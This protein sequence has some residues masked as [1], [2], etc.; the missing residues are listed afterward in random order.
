MTDTVLSVGQLASSQPTVPAKSALSPAFNSMKIYGFLACCRPAPV[1]AGRGSI[2]WQLLKEVAFSERG[3]LWSMRRVIL[4][5]VL[6]HLRS[7][8]ACCLTPALLEWTTTDPENPVSHF[9]WCQITSPPHPIATSVCAHI[10]SWHLRIDAIVFEPG[11]F[12]TVSFRSF[13]IEVN[14]SGAVRFIQRIMDIVIV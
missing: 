3:W 13:W 7:D 10:R 2:T 9:Y 5:R 11:Q 12:V 1:R 8:P 14:L 6:W 4:T